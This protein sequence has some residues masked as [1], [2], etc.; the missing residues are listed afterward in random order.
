MNRFFLER[1]PWVTLE[2]TNACPLSCVMCHVRE[3]D[4]L[5]P[6]DLP[7]PLAEKFVADLLRGRLR[8]AGVRLFWLGEP[9]L[10]PDFA[11]IVRL[12][13]DPELRVRGLVPRIGFDTNGLGLDPERIAALVSTAAAMP[14]HILWSLDAASAPVYERIRRGGDFDRSVAAL[15]A[16]L[17]ARVA[18]GQAFPRVAV[19]F[20]AM[21]ENR[22]E[23]PR[24]LDRFGAMFERRGI[25]PRI[26]LNASFADADGFNLRPRTWQETSGENRQAEMD[27]LYLE[28][29]AGCGIRVRDGSEGVETDPGEVDRVK[30]P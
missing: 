17:D 24:F 16:L 25:R 8:T 5:P 15:E 29:L 12:F 9:T 26:L 13:A 28:A 18:A 23:L 10:H 6:G 21:P 22:G 4:A 19:Q 3:K 7:L 14:V 27:R 11:S 1:P 2:L 20:I 30:R